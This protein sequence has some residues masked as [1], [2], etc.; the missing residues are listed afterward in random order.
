[1]LP[2]RRL[3]SSRQPAAAFRWES[4]MRLIV[5]IVARLVGGGSAFGQSRREYRYP[6][7]LFAPAP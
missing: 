6:E 5:L 7:Q 3:A 4:N 1:V 2:Q